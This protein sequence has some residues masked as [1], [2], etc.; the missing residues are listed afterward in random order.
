MATRSDYGSGGKTK[1][2][3]CA[4][5]LLLA[6]TAVCQA[7][8]D[9][10]AEIHVGV[11][12]AMGVC[13]V[14][15]SPDGRLLA[16]GGM[17][18][19]VHLWEVASRR[20]LRVLR[21]HSEPV[22]AVAFSPDGRLLASYSKNETRLWDV[23]SGR[24]VRR[25]RSRGY[26]FG[27]SVAFSPDGG[28]LATLDDRTNSVRLWDVSSGNEIRSCKGHTE[29]VL[30]V[31]ISSDGRFVASGG[32]DKTVRLWSLSTGREVRTLEGH[33]EAIAAVAFSPD[34]RR[35]ASASADN[36]VRVWD[37]ATGHNV[38]ILQ[39]HV[40][41]VYSV[42]FSP[43][44]RVIASGGGDESDAERGET[45]LWEA[46]SGRE[47]AAVR[48]PAREVWCVAFSP[49]G[50]FVCSAGGSHSVIQVV[51]VSSQRQV[52]AF[53]GFGCRDVGQVAFSRQGNLLATG[54]GGGSV[55][56]WSSSSGRHLRRF[57]GHTGWIGSLAFGPDDRVLATA[58]VD[59]TVR[60][61]DVRSGRELRKISGCTSVAFSCDGVLA[62]GGPDKA[63]RLWAS[64]GRQ[65]RALE[66]PYD[67]KSVTFSQDG[68]LLL[69]RLLGGSLQLWQV[70]DGHEV[71][72]AAHGRLATFSPDGRT[73]ATVT[74][75][76][77]GSGRGRATTVALW[78]LPANREA[79]HFQV[80]DSVASLAFGNDGRVLASASQATALTMRTNVRLWSVDTGRELR[81]LPDSCRSVSFSRD[82]RL[83]ATAS[84]DGIVRLW[85]T[86]SGRL[87]AS[88]AAGTDNTYL[89]WTPE[90]Y[91]VGNPQAEEHVVIR[92][93]DRAQ[94]LGQ[95]RELFYRPDLVSR[96]IAGESVE[97]APTSSRIRLPDAQRPKAG[98]VPVPALPP[99]ANVLAPD[100][101]TG[102]TKDTT[103]VLPQRGIRVVPLS[104]EQRAVEGFDPAESAGL[105]VGVRQFSDLDIREVPY[106]VDDA[107]DLAY[108]FA[109][110]LKLIASSRV[111]LALSGEPQK[112]QSKHRLQELEA[113]GARRTGARFTTL[114]SEVSKTARRAGERG[115]VVMSFATHGYSIEGD[116]RLFGQDSLRTQLSL[117]GLPVRKIK[118]SLSS[119]R[120]PRRLLFFDACREQVDVTRGA[121]ADPKVAMSKK[122]AEAIGDARGMAVFAGTTE[123]GYSYDDHASKNGVFTA[124]VVRGLRGSA[125]A[126][127]RGFITPETL[128]KYVNQAVKDW[129]LAHRP[130]YKKLS[131][132]IL[133][134]VEGQ[135]SSRIP[136]AVDPKAVKKLKR[137]AER[138][139]RLY[140]VLKDRFVQQNTDSITADMVKEIGSLLERAPTAARLAPLLKQLEILQKLG[141]DG[142]QNFALWWEQRGRKRLR[143][144][145]APADNELMEL[146][147]TLYVAG[148]YEEAEPQIRKMLRAQE[149]RLDPDDPHL[150]SIRLLLGKILVARGDSD[151]AVELLRAAFES[152]RKRLGERHWQTHEASL[153]YNWLTSPPRKRAPIL[154]RPPA[155]AVI[156]SGRVVGERGEP[157]ANA[158][159]S[160][161]GAIAD[162]E[163]LS[164]RWWQ[165]GSLPATITQPDGRF[166]L[167]GLRDGVLTLEV[168]GHGFV[169]K[170]YSGVDTRNV[171]K[172][173]GI[174]FV[175]ERSREKR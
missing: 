123:G 121:G 14:A 46:D 21:G 139:E 101:D 111:T 68:R 63:V 4:A 35:L 157:I 67:V 132:G 167:G 5:P 142:D 73:L 127:E 62:T 97:A 47:I 119:C 32:W 103:A 134:N 7:S 133:Y 99:A 54:D 81:A 149:T 116:N 19:G 98:K 10:P 154:L 18:K 83:I 37:V 161:S 66:G 11:G 15:F 90:G 34:G 41:N 92:S 125:L 120:A 96:K 122:F 118:Q 87:L 31:A 79:R 25:L 24:E 60:L 117:T 45:R 53:R 40:G 12:H 75:E 175:L 102:V 22:Q 169:T 70:A 17:E 104:S 61:W 42:A 27:N 107:V 16:S 2:T 44:G 36:T 88:L 159:V 113:G 158:M 38:R 8:K 152:R 174:V 51:E 43:D 148:R 124:A 20:E 29:S 150:A 144:A 30:A 77:A 93:G 48:S 58:G 56:L 13:A 85:E 76:K 128:A 143:A 171:N 114:L 156:V 55:R 64:T 160:V 155:N 163:E 57:D 1:W 172:S 165:T 28:R 129:V 80:H 168:R 173:R 6:A 136:L 130:K 170:L 84:L 3:L 89:A 49:D 108:L 26:G 50:R 112:P 131:D 105:F 106:A 153:A 33:K 100:P 162:I 137:E 86:A 65:I 126:D 91:F 164:S 9:E 147:L 69:A 146:A 39:G 166:F 110:D 135:H 71:H 138:R 145:L 151:G 94:A 59:E 141:A 72:S 78:D 95:Y 115:V 74:G 82:H 140:R 109:S 23:P 52:D